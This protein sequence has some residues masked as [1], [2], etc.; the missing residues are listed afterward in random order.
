[1]HEREKEPCSTAGAKRGQRPKSSPDPSH[2]VQF[3][4]KRWRHFRLLS[5]GPH[6]Y[7]LPSAP[8]LR[9]LPLPVRG[10]RRAQS[11]GKICDRPRPISFRFFFCC[12]PAALRG[13]RRANSLIEKKIMRN[14]RVFKWR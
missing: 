3:S 4:R 11:I 6:P 5:T 2:G 14:F 8:T 10:E 12:S 7:G 9:D 13:L 1:M